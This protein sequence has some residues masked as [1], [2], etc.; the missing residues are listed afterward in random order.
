MKDIK[1][2]DMRVQP[3]D[4]AFLIDDSERAI[5]AADAAPSA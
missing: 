5:S 4:S 3:G 2:I 1:I